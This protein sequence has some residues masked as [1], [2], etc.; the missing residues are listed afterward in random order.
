M[1]FWRAINAEVWMRIYFDD[2]ATALDDHSYRAGF[3]RARRP[4]RRTRGPRRPQ[5]CSRRAKPNPG[6]HLFLQIGD[7]IFARVPLQSRVITPADDVVD[8]ILEAIDHA[9]GVDVDDGDLVLVSEKA[10]SISQG[11][12]L[13]VADIRTHARGPPALAL[14]EPHAGGRGPRPS[15]PR[16]SSPSTRSGSPRILLAAVAGRGH[17]TRSGCA[18]SSTAS[19]VDG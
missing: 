18:A 13:P 9:D 14:R 16:C 3:V 7:D 4:R 15:R 12:A 6:N 17:A 11:N 5:R 1:F 8:A 19:P 2:D 10:L